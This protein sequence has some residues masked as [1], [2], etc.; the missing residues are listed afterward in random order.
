MRQSR[1]FGK[2]SKTISKDLKVASHKY[3]HQGGFIR[4]SV[5]GRYYF[6][7]LGIRVRDKIA[8]IIEDEM[9]KAGAQKMITPT[10][11]P[12]ELW[13]E[14]N[15]TD[16][17]GF[18]LMTLEDRRGSAFALGGTAEE[19]I[20]DLVRGYNISYKDLPFNIY[21]F[22]S[23]FRDELRARGG[24]LRVRE[25]VMKDGYSFHSNEECFKKEYRVMWDTYTRIFEQLGMKSYAVEADNGYIGGDYCHE[26][27]VECDAGE[28]VFFV[29]ED[30]KY[31][32]HEDVAKFKREE[33][34][35]EDEIKDF[36]VVEQP[37]WV[38]TME[39]VKKHYDLPTWRFLKNVVYRNRVSEEI[40]IATIRGD[41]EINK[42]KLEQV[43]DMVGTLEDAT[44][45]DLA[46]IETK[47]G[48]VH[49][50]GHEKCRYIGDLSLWTVKNFIGGQKEEKTDSINVNYGRDFEHEIT[51]DIAMAKN[52]F[53]TE[54]GKQKLKRKKGVE[55]GNIFQLGKHYSSKMNATFV[56]AKGEQQQY[57]MGCYGIGLGRNMATIVEKNHDDKGIIWPE[58]VAPFK[59][60]L[61]GIA[62]KDESVQKEIDE[63]YK[64]LQE[65]GV[66]VLYDDRDIN[67]GGKFADADIIGCPY[68]IVIS[69]K[70][71]KDGKI[72]LKRRK[73]D[74]VKMILKEELLTELLK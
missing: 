13:K 45:K 57:Y 28:S 4:E 14:T 43:L 7:P 30:E 68:R 60:H 12:L 44:E 22:S 36:E 5:A 55:V 46:S 24:L 18:E 3:L 21:Q 38:K 25:F 6:L 66:E 26:F 8:K 73:E 59:V 2:T 70:T 53:L 31:V 65:K 32:A 56:D 42:T 48:Y 50:W 41:L 16:T 63:F 58:K 34:N 20:V 27:V 54:D 23:K 9:N 35:S 62:N 15:R 61:I 71:I 19:M 39:D 47:T 40:I 37:E 11:H 52:D 1:L 49:A 33:M 51:A 72:E 74:D 64:E 17:A 29:S 67:P 10:L 69:Q